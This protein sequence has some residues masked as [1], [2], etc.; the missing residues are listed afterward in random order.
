MLPIFT[1]RDCIKAAQSSAGQNCVRVGRKQ[2]W[3]V[4]WDDKLATDDG[5]DKAL[6]SNEILILTDEQFDAFQAAL[7]AGGF[8]HGAVLIERQLDGAYVFTAAETRDQTVQEVALS[9]DADE[10]D[11]FLDGVRRH[12]F[13][14][15]RFRTAAC[16]PDSPEHCFAGL[17]LA[18]QVRVSVGVVGLQGAPGADSS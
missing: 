10:F 1:P 15:D 7:R 16:L 2:G 17:G 8:D 13:D 9:F 12:E 5:R 14:L 11:A 3:T 6:P 18:S 4:I